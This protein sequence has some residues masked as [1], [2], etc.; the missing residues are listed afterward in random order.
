MPPESTEAGKHRFTSGE[1]V[2]FDF[3]VQ[4]VLDENAEDCRPE[5]HKTDLARNVWEDHELA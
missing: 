3:R 2:T 1:S 4:E 5:E